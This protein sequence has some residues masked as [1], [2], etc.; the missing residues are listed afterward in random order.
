V[1]AFRTYSHELGLSKLFLFCTSWLLWCDEQQNIHYTLPSRFVPTMSA[2]HGSVDHCW[3]RR[4][5]V[6][7]FCSLI[8][9][10]WSLTGQYTWSAEVSPLYSSPCA[11]CLLW[12]R[13]QYELSGQL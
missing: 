1:D 4:N 3:R 10:M 7:L 11:S 2:L 6:A 12:W 5:H 9:R 8:V 13:M